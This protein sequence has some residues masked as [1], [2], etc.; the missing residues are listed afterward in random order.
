MRRTLLF[1]V[2]AL[3]CG[4]GVFAAEEEGIWV[5]A[6]YGGRRMISEDGQTWSITGEWSQPGGD[7]S[8]NLM[9]AVY[10]EGKFVVVGGGGGGRFGT[11]GGHVLVSRD[12]R[13]WKETWSPQSRVNPIVFGDG[14][15]VVG[16]PQRKLYWSDDAENWQ[17]GAVLEDRVATHFRHGA[18]GNGVFV[19]VGNHGGN[20]GPSWCA[21]SP[22]G[23]TVTNLRTDMPGHG[24]LVYGNGQFLMMTSHSDA[25]LVGSVDGI[26]WNP[27]QIADGARLRWIVWTSEE[28]VAGDGKTAWFSSNG[29]DWTA[30]ELQVR[31]RVVWSDG[32]QFITTGWPGKMGWTERGGKWHASPELTANGINEVIFGKPTP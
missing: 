32:H 21:V 8:H 7:D 15:F 6:G 17:E 29:H 14:R 28:F 3:C 23:Q 26:E 16:G 5:A 10:A 4:Q 2:L 1:I 31:G 22:D 25:E 9:S 24:R 18:Y 19:F 11:P 13:E 20:G 12:G 27:V 30:E